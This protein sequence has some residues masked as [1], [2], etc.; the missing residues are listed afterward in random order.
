MPL[1]ESAFSCSPWIEA[2]AE[3]ICTVE[4]RSPH[5]DTVR[6]GGSVVEHLAKLD[7]R[8]TGGLR[9]EP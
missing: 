1:L 2:T 4:L 9:C 8:A 3:G 6:L 7:L 5:L